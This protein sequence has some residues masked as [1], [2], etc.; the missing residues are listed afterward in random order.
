MLWVVA[1]GAFVIGGIAFDETRDLTSRW[2][3]Y[4]LCIVLTVAGL[5]AYWTGKADE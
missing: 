4:V 3:A 2:M 1:S 5:F